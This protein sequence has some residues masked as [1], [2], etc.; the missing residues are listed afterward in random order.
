MIT[1]IAFLLG[2]AWHRELAAGR[3][4][5]PS[6]GWIMIVAGLAAALTFPIS[7]YP[8]LVPIG[9]LVL[10]GPRNLHK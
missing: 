8:A 3:R 4:L 9:I 7:G 5:P 10:R 1:P 6:A 2:G